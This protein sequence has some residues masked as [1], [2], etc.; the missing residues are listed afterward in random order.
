[1]TYPVPDLETARAW[2]QQVLGHEPLH[3]SPFAVVFAPR[4]HLN[5]QYM[6]SRYLT[7]ADGSRAGHALASIFLATATHD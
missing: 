5:T 3:S 1:M 7:R 2:Y 6:E 4:E